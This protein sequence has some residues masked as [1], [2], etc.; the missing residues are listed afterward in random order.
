MIRPVVLDAGALIALDRNNRETWALVK[1]IS[2]DG[3]SIHVPT[4]V[5]AQA[6]RDGARQALLARALGHC[7]EVVLDGSLARTAG[8][9][10]GQAGTAD[11]VDATVALVAGLIGERTPALVLTSDPEDIIHLAGTLGVDVRIELV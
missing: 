7:E 6:W 5:I 1:A 10:C 4:G 11:V 8:L 3:G 2:E 9:L